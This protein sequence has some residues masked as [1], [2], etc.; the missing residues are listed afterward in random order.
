MADQ[1]KGETVP[2]VPTTPDKVM[3]DAAGSGSEVKVDAASSGS[4]VKVDGA[5]SGQK[6]DDAEKPEVEGK[7]ASSGIDGDV[8][9]SWEEIMT[10][11]GDK[12]AEEV[13]QMGDDE[14]NKLL[15]VDTQKVVART[16]RSTCGTAERPRRRHSPA[17]W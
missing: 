11:D 16:S 6:A 12:N 13:A 1:A 17:C 2:S 5:G 14:L 9:K 8:P 7:T 10:E 4:E 3:I 15:D